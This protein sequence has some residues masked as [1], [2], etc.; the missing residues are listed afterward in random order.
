M[1]YYVVVSRDKKV[2]QSREY[3]ISD[4]A[5]YIIKKRGFT[6]YRVLAQD[7]SELAP[8]RELRKSEAKELEQKLYPNLWE[9]A[10]YT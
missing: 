10:A 8:M 6:K 5:S 3:S 1:T 2:P 4:A 9:M 7:G